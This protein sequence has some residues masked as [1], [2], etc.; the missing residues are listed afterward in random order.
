MKNLCKKTSKYILTTGALLIA[1]LGMFA[2]C[3]CAKSDWSLDK[4]TIKKTLDDL[5]NNGIKIGDYNGLAV[6]NP[7]FNVSKD[8]INAINN[9]VTTGKQ[10]NDDTSNVDLSV[11]SVIL[12]RIT[13]LDDNLKIVEAT[14]LI[15]DK[16]IPRPI[17]ESFDSPHFTNPANNFIYTIAYI[18]D[19]DNNVKGFANARNN[20][21]LPFQFYGDG[22]SI[23]NIKGDL[24]SY[25]KNFDKKIPFDPTKPDQ[26]VNGLPLFDNRAAL[27]KSKGPTD[28]GPDRILSI[29][30]AFFLASKDYNP[31]HLSAPLGLLGDFLLPAFAGQRI[32]D[33]II[34][35][36]KSLTVAV[37]EIGNGYN[38]SI[39]ANQLSFAKFDIHYFKG[40]TPNGYIPVVS[41]DV[42][43]SEIKGSAKVTQHLAFYGNVD[44]QYSKTG[45]N[46][47]V[48]Y[49]VSDLGLF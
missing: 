40:K 32:F 42:L 45:T 48:G 44:F 28:N 11:S 9:L 8:D 7:N 38:W 22:L 4:S 6:Q 12:D 20:P 25:N 49:K 37:N 17:K 24:I 41:S 18:T 35:Y 15:N 43:R 30:N 31:K 3:G 39:T 21:L 1:S 29:A 46:G 36:T 23:S 13:P 33:F 34:G 26:N 16:D 2:G 5:F 10:T 14:V 19:K 27:D 47:Y